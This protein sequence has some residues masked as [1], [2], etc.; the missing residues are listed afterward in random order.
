[1]AY[2]P[3]DVIQEI[4]E[5]T[6]IVDIAS[7]YIQ[8]SKKGRNYLASCPFHE[9]RS[10][11][12]TVSQEKQ[13][14]KCFSCG[15][16]GNVFGLV[17]EMEGL[18]F[19][20]AVLKVADMNN[21]PIDARYSQGISDENKLHQPLKDIHQKA[22]EFYQ[23]Y[24][25][26]TTNGQEALDYLLRRGLTEETLKD[27]KIGLA[28]A[29]SELLY[30]YLAK[31]G[32]SDE[33][34]VQSGIFF[35]AEDGDMVDR[36]RKRIIFPLSDQ[37]GVVLG[38]S[39]RTLDDGQK[40]KYLNS[41]DTPIFNKSNLLYNLDQARHTIRQESQVLIM[42]GFMDVIALWQAGV[43]NA[44]ATMGTALTSNHLN[45]LTTHDGY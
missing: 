26:S 11:S 13:I 37:R 12:F 8:L 2:I 34:L 4:K 5:Q 22:S 33:Q 32:Y 44:V 15:R 17:S 25:M 1:M 3:E 35:L 39:G 24:L 41:P 21:I 18:T 43:K 10:P 7:Q 19:P 42:E 30:Q 29:K 45:T 27:F 20:E 6:D 31:E 36:F 28:P 23:Y 14:F 16:G 38:F 9:D 40:A